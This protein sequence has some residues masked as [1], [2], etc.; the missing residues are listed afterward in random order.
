MNTDEIAL[1]I[2]KAHGCPVKIIDGFR[3]YETKAFLRPVRYKNKM[4]LDYELSE[5]GI[6][7]NSC[8]VYIGPPQPDITT[9]PL[10]IIISDSTRSYDIKRA[11]KIC[12][13]EDCVYIWAVLSPRV[14]E[15]EYEHIG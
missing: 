7:D 10:N 12:I 6:R 9:D 14:R 8:V 1:K 3:E 4:Y 2:F 11:D 13:G 5:M 15:N